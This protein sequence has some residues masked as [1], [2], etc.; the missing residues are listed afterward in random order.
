M[1]FIILIILFVQI[2]YSSNYIIDYQQIEHKLPDLNDFEVSITSYTK[3]IPYERV[4]L[5]V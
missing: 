3:D 4:H 1:N 5:Y 2:A